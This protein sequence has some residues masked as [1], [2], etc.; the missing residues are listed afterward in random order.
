MLVSFL[1]LLLAFLNVVDALLNAT[2]DD[3]NPMISYSGE[4]E[5][6][7]THPSSSDFGGSHT[8][9]SDSNARATFNF[10]GVAVYYLA[11]RWPYPVSTRLSLDGGPSTL[12][13]LTDPNTPP[14]PAGGPESAPSSVAWSATGLTNKSH[15]LVATI[16]NFI[17]VDGFIYTIDNSA[18][19][20]TQSSS[21]ATLSSSVSSSATSAASSAGTSTISSHHALAI[22]LG[23][24]FGLTVFIAGA[25]LL[26]TLYQR[27]RQ[28]QPHSKSKTTVIADDWGSAQR[29]RYA[30]VSKGPPTLEISDV[31]SPLF[32]TY[33]FA[34]PW[35]VDDESYL[36]SRSHGL[37]ASEG[38]SVSSYGRVLPPGAQAA[39]IPDPYL[40]HPD[41]A[42]PSSSQPVEVPVLRNPFIWRKVQGH[43]PGPPGYLEM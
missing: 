33:P 27:R 29:G 26:F 28:R 22:G 25:L 40:P 35:E 11:P 23:T 31:S 30:S 37:T 4:W 39:T 42:A 21:S 15:I 8:L 14:I 19:S 7:S 38:S 17:I 36:G 6:S 24:A 34:D 1:P 9:S 10:T 13:N 20:S 32:S 41:D 5:A 3:V 2:I 18:S 43:T 16:G 12:V